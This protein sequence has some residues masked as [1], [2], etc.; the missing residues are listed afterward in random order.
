MV[1]TP[2]KQPK[3]IQEEDEN[4]DRREKP[5]GL[6]DQL[7]ADHVLEE[8]VETLHEPFPEILQTSRD[9]LKLARREPGAHENS[10]GHDPGHH[11]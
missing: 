7:G 8:I 5:E 3:P 11:H 10:S 6:L 2:G 1:P 9:R 4:E